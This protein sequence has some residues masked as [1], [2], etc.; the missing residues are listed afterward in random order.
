LRAA[1]QIRAHTS[2]E[3]LARE[4]CSTAL[5]VTSASE[6]SLVRW[7][8]AS[9]MGQVQHATGDLGVSTGFKVAGDSLVGR[10]CVD[11]LPMVL[12]DASTLRRNE[13][14]GPGD[15]FTRAGSAAVIPIVRDDVCL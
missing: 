14:F 10:T 12:E 6:A 13:V 11:G 9:G 15:G 5:E 3:A 8:A 1:D 2:P 7:D 4:L